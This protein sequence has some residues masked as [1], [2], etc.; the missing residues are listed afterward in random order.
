MT[1]YTLILS[2]LLISAPAL[3]KP[4]AGFDEMC[5][6]FTEAT[7]RNISGQLL[8]EYIDNNVKKRINSIDAITVYSIIL[9]VEPKER[10]ALFKQSA[11][12]SL[13]R[14]WDCPAIEQLLQ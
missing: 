7:R 9:Q 2:V 1:I 8:S 14:E 5:D 11:E 6:I 3:F 4:K 10:Y 12:Y 13:K